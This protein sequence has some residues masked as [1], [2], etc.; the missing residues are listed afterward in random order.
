MERIF[1]KAN[2]ALAFVFAGILAAGPAIADK[3]SWTGGGKSEKSEYREK[4]KDKKSSERDADKRSPRG[5]VAATVKMRQY[6]GDRERTIAQRYY[7]DE[8]RR[9]RCPPGLAKKHNGCMP[10]GQARKWTVGRPLPRDVIY[11]EVP[12]P[13][14]VQLSPPP[15]GYRYVRVAND[16]LLIALGTGMV[17]DAIQDLGAMR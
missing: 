17:M 14:V 7:S 8:L 2:C 11:Y 5:G 3:P 9:G 12:R 4:A 16:I 15:A 10:P 1:F 13:L 6:F